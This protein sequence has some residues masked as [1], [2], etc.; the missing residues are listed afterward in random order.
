MINSTSTKSIVLRSVLFLS[1]LVNNTS[2]L[3][4]LCERGLQ[5]IK[6][7]LH[8]VESNGKTCAFKAIDLAKIDNPDS[9]Q[10][11]NDIAKFRGPCCTN[12]EPPQ[13]AVA[14]TPAPVYSGRIGSYNQC[15]LCR[16]GDYPYQTS[17]VINLLYVG[18]G[19]CAQFYDYAN[20][21]LIQNHMC[22]TLQFFAYE[23]CGCGEFNPRFNPNHPLNQQAQQAPE[24]NGPPPKTP[25]PTNRPTPRPTMKPTRAPQP[26][27]PLTSRPT[28]VPTQRPTP[29]P[30]LNPILATPGFNAQD[31][32]STVQ[33]NPVVR[34]NPDDRDNKKQNKMGNTRG[35]GGQGGQRRRGLKGDR[36]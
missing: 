21:G 3:C 10:C 30:A 23:P 28:L 32:D 8:V 5:D 26:T 36:S 17:M 6:W 15:D 11:K 31:D 25:N 4:N 33:F 34:K 14:P 22:Q 19:S 24:L 1:L 13:V 7:P 18:V 29:R 20:N 9:S 27:T 16:D 35:R 12:D 2:A